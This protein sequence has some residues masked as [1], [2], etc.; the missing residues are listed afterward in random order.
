MGLFS[1]I[2]NQTEVPAQW[3]ISKTIPIYK[4]KGDKTDIEN[5]RP[6]SNLCSSSKIFEKVILKRILDIQTDQ[7]VDLTGN[8]QHGFKKKRSTTSISLTIQTII[9]HAMDDDNLAIMASLDLSS[10]FDMVNVD[11]LLKRLT[12]MGLPEDLV[13]LIKVWL[14]NRSYFG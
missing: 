7:G 3:L 1:R 4:S 6:I 10:A 13:S 9:A 2:Y 5:Y 14:Q 11:L 8:S 12:I